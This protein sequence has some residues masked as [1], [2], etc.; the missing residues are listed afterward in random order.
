MICQRVGGEC[1]EFWIVR[2]E[3]KLRISL[4]DD[5][6]LWLKEGWYGSMWECM[7]GELQLR[8]QQFYQIG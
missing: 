1:F 4:Q 6:I 8:S 2:G 3:A 5:G 7:K